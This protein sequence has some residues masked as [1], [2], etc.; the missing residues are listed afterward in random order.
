MSRKIRANRTR[1][2]PVMLLLAILLSLSIAKADQ[3]KYPDPARF[4]NAVKKFEAADRIKFPAEGSVLCIGS[5]SIRMWHEWIE[6]DLAPLEIIPRGF[7][8]SNTN[9]LLHYT[10]RIVLPYKPRA[11]VV[12]EGDNDIAQGISPEK[13][14]ETFSKFTA[15]VNKKLPDCRIYFLAIKPSIA[16]WRLW[17]KMQQA[18]KLIAEKCKKEPRLTYV[19]IASPML[20]ENG[21]PKKEIFKKDNLHLN[22]GGY[23]I[24]K[25][26]LKPI[27]EKTELKFAR[28][29]SKQSV[30]TLPDSIAGKTE[31]LNKDFLLYLPKSYAESKEL[32]LMI[33]LHG[34][35]ERG[36]NLKKVTVH[37][38]PKLIE[39]GKDFP[40]IVVSPQ[41]TKD[42]KGK[43]W[44]KTDDL[45]QLLDYVKDCYN[46]DEDRIYLTGLSMGGYATW[47]WI[48]KQPDTFA[49]AVPICGGGQPEKAKSIANLPIWVFHGAK[50]KTV[51]IEKSRQ[52][53]DALKKHG[54]NV[55]FKIYPNA[56]H[57]SWTETYNNPELYKWLAKQF[58]SPKR[59]RRD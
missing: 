21:K 54:S 38:P 30:V 33:F 19:D 47:D 41:C 23:M 12:Y 24:W 56:P 48:T 5:S 50:D 55:K 16:R 29:I 46:I 52:M 9:D 59:E 10:D 22:R 20:D 51:P 17:P 1:L 11:I 18:N 49:A 31:F 37:G 2:I 53:V 15:K 57:D 14:S 58:K 34:M 40:F 13:I 26:V 44:W 36:T 45:S 42:I 39:Q 4:E 6:Y 28:R 3:N 25:N 27:L 43:G 8:G 35:G 7:G 32:P